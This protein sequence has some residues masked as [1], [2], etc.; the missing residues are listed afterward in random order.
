MDF[1]GLVENT[2]E[3]YCID[4]E[5]LSDICFCTLKLTTSTY[6][7]LNHLVSATT[8]LRFPGQLNADLRKLAV[9]MVPFP[10]SISSCQ[11]SPP[12]QQ[13]EPAVPRPHGA[14][15][16]PA[17]VRRQKHDGR[18]R[19]TPWTLPDGG[20]RVPRPH[21]H[22]GSGRAD[23]ERA[24]QEQQILRGVD[25]KQREDGRLR[26]PAKRPQDGRHLDRQQHGHPGAVQTHLRA[27]HC[28]VPPA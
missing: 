4:N 7:D 3:P 5:A 22:E 18:L 11:A 6:G 21:V 10:V 24:E 23:A 1:A 26:H 12:D 20:R 19:P 8:C 15:A 9:N 28:H 27:V 17:G 16:H 25:P 14:R 2:D 13:G